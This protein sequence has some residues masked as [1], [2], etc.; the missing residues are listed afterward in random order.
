MTDHRIAA[1][2]AASRPRDFG[3]ACVRLIAPQSLFELVLAQTTRSGGGVRTAD[4][5]LPAPTSACPPTANQ[6]QAQD[7]AA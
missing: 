3:S 5:R 2:R 6:N 1:F 4:V 7:C